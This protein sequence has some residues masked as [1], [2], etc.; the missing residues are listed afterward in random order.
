[1]LRPCVVLLGGKVEQPDRER[2]ENDEGALTTCNARSR[3][4]HFNHTTIASVRS[5]NARLQPA[6]MARRLQRSRSFSL[7]TVFGSLQQAA[8]ARSRL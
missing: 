4:W 7:L 3:S 1:M 6:G 8:A 2:N 5:W